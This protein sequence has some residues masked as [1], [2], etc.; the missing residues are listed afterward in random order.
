M[1]RR[2]LALW[3]KRPLNFCPKPAFGWVRSR[4]RKISSISR[5][6]LSGIPVLCLELARTLFTVMIPTSQPRDKCFSSQFSY[7]LLGPA[8]GFPTLR[9]QSIGRES[10]S[11]DR[12]LAVKIRSFLCSPC[13]SGQGLPTLTLYISV[14]GLIGRIH[15]SSGRINSTMQKNETYPLRY[16]IRDENLH[17]HQCRWQTLR[18]H[19]PGDARRPQEE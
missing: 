19:N 17:A 2:A 9:A 5:S 10:S 13:R 18:K 8:K 6:Y 15:G 16:G 11:H 7:G 14:V 12:G 3:C 4:L 1:L